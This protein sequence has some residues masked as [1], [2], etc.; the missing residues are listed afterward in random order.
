MADI[1]GTIKAVDVVAMPSLWEASGLVAMETLVAGVPLVV[2]DASGLR[3]VTTDTPTRM[4]PMRD[5]EALLHAIIDMSAP[6]KRF[7]A[8]AFSPVAAQRFDVAETR[9]RVAAL[10]EDL[11]AGH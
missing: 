9:R 3:E 1:A 5:P 2:S 6:E 10:Y 11:I 7:I 4:V 8:Q